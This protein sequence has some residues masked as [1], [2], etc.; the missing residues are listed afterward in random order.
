MYAFFLFFVQWN[1]DLRKRQGTCKMCLVYRGFVISRFCFEYFTI[2]GGVRKLLVIPRS[3]L[4][5]VRYIEDRGSTVSLSP[6]YWESLVSLVLYPYVSVKWKLPHAPPRPTPG[7]TPG[8]WHLCRLGEEGIWLS[9]SSRGWGIW[10]P[11][12]RGGEFELRPRFHVKSL[13]WRAMMGDAVLKDFGGKD[14][15]FVANWLQGEGL[16]KLCAVFFLF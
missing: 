6:F 5:L 8:I 12:F 9:E 2:T 16:N 4:Y 7:H 1:L 11:C 15:A 13:A 3:S 14:C 10:S